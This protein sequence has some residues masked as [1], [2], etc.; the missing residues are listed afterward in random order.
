MRASARKKSLNVA[1]PKQSKNSE[2]VL[3][4][5]RRAGMAAKFVWRKPRAAGIKKWILRFGDR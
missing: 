4:D 1:T 3:K 2:T 5:S